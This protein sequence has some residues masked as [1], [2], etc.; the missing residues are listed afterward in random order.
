MVIGMDNSY[1]CLHVYA[2][3]KIT[4]GCGG[5]NENGSCWLRCLNASQL[6]DF[7]LRRTRRCGSV[8]V[9]VSLLEEVFY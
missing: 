1:T 3:R 2:N 4:W 6:V 8:G 9:G 7:F 5:L